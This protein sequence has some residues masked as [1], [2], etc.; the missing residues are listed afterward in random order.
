MPQPPH[1]IKYAE[2]RRKINN[3]ATAKAAEII[4][5][6]TGRKIEDYNTR[7]RCANAVAFRAM[8]TYLA[9]E[10]GASYYAIGKALHRSNATVLHAYDVYIN[11]ATAW[12]PLAKIREKVLNVRNIYPYEDN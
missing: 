12:Q 4:F 1:L 8:Y 3:A 9:V 10:L 6:A 2:N 5:K 7:S 11:N